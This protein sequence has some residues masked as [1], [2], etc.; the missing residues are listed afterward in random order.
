MLLGDLGV[1]VPQWDEKHRL[2]LD[3]ELRLASIEVSNG[4]G[5]LDAPRRA[6]H[7]NPATGAAP[8]HWI[9]LERLQVAG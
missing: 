8:L 2:F 4:S 7:W 6:V 5:E 9:N 3:G 1:G